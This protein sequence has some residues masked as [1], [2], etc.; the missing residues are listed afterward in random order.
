MKYYSASVGDIGPNGFIHGQPV[1]REPQ[2]PTAIRHVDA[3]LDPELAIM[4]QDKGL[5]ADALSGDWQ[6]EAACRGMDTES[7]FPEANYARPKNGPVPPARKG[8]PLT[9]DQ[10]RALCRGCA[11]WRQCRITAHVEYND[12][13]IWSKLPSERAET[14]AADSR[15]RSE[16]ARARRDAAKTATAAEV[17]FAE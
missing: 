8:V 3:K 16:L 14:H 10:V 2:L 13:G 9:F 11:V 7:F 4:V 15:R 5:L 12:F 6:T 1:P 17:E